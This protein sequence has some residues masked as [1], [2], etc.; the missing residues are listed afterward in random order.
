VVMTDVSILCSILET[1]SD[2][3]QKAITA[4]LKQKEGSIPPKSEL[5]VD[6]P[7]FISTNVYINR[8]RQLKIEESIEVEGRV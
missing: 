4:T 3:V 2:K 6:N 1:I 7:C 8:K 5:S